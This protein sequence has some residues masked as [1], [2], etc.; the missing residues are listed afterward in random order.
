M[1]ILQ[2]RVNALSDNK[3]ALLEKL[4]QVEKAKKM[5]SKLDELA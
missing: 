3:K 4:I 2:S 1:D 5:K